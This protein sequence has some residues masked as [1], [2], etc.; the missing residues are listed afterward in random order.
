MNINSMIS[1]LQEYNTL[2]KDTKK[3]L[4]DTLNENGNEDL[5]KLIESESIT[6]SKFDFKCPKMEIELVSP[7]RLTSCENWVHHSSSGNCLQLYL[8]Q[9]GVDALTINEIAFLHKKHPETIKSEVN[10]A[11]S[12]LRTGAVNVA[13]NN[14]EIT[15]KFTVI[16]S[17]KICCVCGDKVEELRS[18]KLLIKKIG[19]VYCSDTCKTKVHPA[20]IILEY[21]Y[22][23]PVEEVLSWAVSKFY[24]L[25]SLEQALGITRWLIRELIDKYLPMKSNKFKQKKIKFSRRTWHK[26]NWMIRHKEEARPYILMIYG[27]YGPP[28]INT[29]K[30]RKK[31]NTLIDLDQFEIG[32]LK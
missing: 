32:L 12:T 27:K 25:S 1:L 23:V 26:P 29:S 14:A 18:S 22:G 30:I 4:I 2:D 21:N 9:Q 13:I 31:I 6:A 7:C 19:L 11:M 28:Q 24:T 17:D 16:H 3:F 15:P 8:K 10:A 5:V 20:V